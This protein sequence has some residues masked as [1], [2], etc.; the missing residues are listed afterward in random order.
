VKIPQDIID[1]VREA[2]DI[3]SL[4]GESVRL[5]KAG[6]SFKGL[7]PFHTEKSPSFHVNPER[8]IYHCFGCGAGGNAITFLIE[9][10]KMTFPEA[11]RH[12]ADRAGIVIPAGGD[13]G[14]DTELARIHEALAFAAEFFEERRKHP[15]AGEPARAYLAARGF[16]AQV[17]EEFAL[18]FAPDGWSNL[19]DVAKTR[20]TQDILVRAGLVIQKETGG[21]YDRFRNRLMVPITSSTG[22]V[23]GFGGR[24]LGDDPAKYIN[25]P[26]SPV[27]QKSQVLFGLPL[28]REAMRRSETAILV[29][30]YFDLMRVHA[31]GLTNVVAVSGTAFTPQQ[32]ALLKRH[33]SRVQLVFDGDSAG[34]NAAWKAAGLCL[35]A[36][37]DP[38]F[39][40]LPEGDDPDSYLQR[41]GGDAFR[42]VLDAAQDVVEF[43]RERLLPKTGKEEAL[44]RFVDLVRGVPDPIRRRLLV[45]SAAERLRFDEAVLVQV[46][47]GGRLPAGRTGAPQLDRPAPAAELPVAEKTLLAIL[48]DQPR[49]LQELGGLEA[50]DFEDERSRVILTQLS[51]LL[52]S[53]EPRHRMIEWA[54]GTPTLR[55][56]SQLLDEPTHGGLMAA[57]DCA[58]AL[59]R[60]RLKT[61]I[62]E[63]RKELAAAE[64]NRES[65]QVRDLLERIKELSNQT[66]TLTTGA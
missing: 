54:Q 43:T 50:E 29:E 7:C 63:L 55:V 28:A 18:G 24:T 49:L 35:E 15:Y 20:Y 38:S 62:G 10:G 45:Q 26:E 60:R 21:A 6:R 57:L 64:R 41:E 2:T 40:V 14:A 53:T 8:Q 42:T 31:A 19:F 1:R 61:E 5:A 30:G 25:S 48:I 39:V 32:A 37:L 65:E 22:R 51:T 52:E 3:V 12:L 27:Y 11:V 44:R 58:R 16:D 66:R 36:G 34:L 47:E 17:I 33:V 56:L 59:R 4:V 9:H 23:I 13:E 46:V